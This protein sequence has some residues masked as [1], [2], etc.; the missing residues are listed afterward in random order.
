MTR[1]GRIFLPNLIIRCCSYRSPLST[2]EN[3]ISSFMLEMNETAFLC[4]NSS[5]GAL[6][7]IDELG[8][9]TGNQDGLAI[10]WAVAEFLLSKQAMTFFVTHYPQLCRLADVYASVQNQHLQAA[11][12]TSH[13]GQI[14]YTHKVEAGPC[15]ST[16][17][18]GIDMASSCGWP[19]DTLAEVCRRVT[20]D[21]A[22]ALLWRGL[23]IAD[24]LFSHPRLI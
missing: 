19:R 14:Q 2:A 9:A 13:D 6:I 20:C 24:P 1:V 11:V 16:P 12:P 21:Q 5:S 7:L 17:D 23:E 10:A 18:Y 15:I 3:N 22:L 4:N 8:R